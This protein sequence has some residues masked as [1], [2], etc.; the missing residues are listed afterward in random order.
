MPNEPGAHLNPLTESRILFC[1]DL[2][3]DSG[4]G[5][6]APE[7]GSFGRQRVIARLEGFDFVFRSTQ[8]RLGFER[9]LFQG[10][11]GL[12][13]DG[14]VGAEVVD[15]ENAEGDEDRV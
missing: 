3:L 7:F 9:V 5:D 1:Q 14:D 4:L 2:S 12:L 15:A 13:V 8:R 6:F 10:A 11:Y